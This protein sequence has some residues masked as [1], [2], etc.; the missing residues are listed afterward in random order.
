MNESTTTESTHPHTHRANRFAVLPVARHLNLDTIL[1]GK[2]VTMAFLDSGFMRHPDLTEPDDRIVAFDDVGATGCERE[3]GRVARPWLW[4]GT[5]TSVVAAGNGRLSGGLYKG[6]AHG[7]R[8]A[9]VKVSDRGAIRDADIARGL[10]WIL[11]NHERYGI[12]V[13]NMS[14]GGD[15]NASFE[16]STVDRLAAEAVRAGIVVVVA[17]GN[18]GCTENHTPIPPANEP[19]VITV[20]GYDDNNSRFAEPGAYC[21]SYGIT[22][23][24]LL[25]PEIVAPAIWI[26]APV[27]PGTPEYAR[28]TAL[29][30]I[31]VT[32]DALLDDLPE[33]IWERAGLGRATSGSDAARLRSELAEALVASKIV[34]THYQ[35]VDGTSFA[36]PIVA[37]LVALMLEANPALTPAT[38]KSILVSTARRIPGVPVARQGYGMI[39]ARRA[40]VL[41]SRERHTVDGHAVRPPYCDGDGLVFSLHD[42]EATSVAVAGDF[43]AWDSRAT[44]LARDAR[45]IWRARVRVDAGVRYKFVV[46]GDRWIEDPSNAVREADGLGGFNS[47]VEIVR[48]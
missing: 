16:A 34:A 9:L 33:A 36:A 10:E 6:L 35:H 44:P 3:T 21:S 30:E 4:H 13:L 17:A 32:P 18:A 43:N 12:R 29:A 45:G 26:P 5:Q 8:V 37:S 39:D 1:S 22:I 19:S 2:G 41:A 25:K 40:I 28:A 20:G 11:S 38:V 42:D 27:L 46:G 15:A 23:D 47:V 24:G 48:G 31:E 14:L 7:A